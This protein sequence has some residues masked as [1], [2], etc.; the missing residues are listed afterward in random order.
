VLN[1]LSDAF[2][3]YSTYKM[4]VQNK[5]RDG[6]G[7]IKLQDNVNLLYTRYMIMKRRVAKL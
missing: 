2:S 1:L 3:Q 5:F 7:T 6:D 4:E